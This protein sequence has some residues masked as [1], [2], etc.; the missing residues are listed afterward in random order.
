MRLTCDQNSRNQLNLPH[1]TKTK[2]DILKNG[3]QQCQSGR[4]S[5]DLWWEGFVKEVGFE[6]G[7]KEWR[8][9]GCWEWWIYGKS[10]TGMRRKIRVQDG[11]T[12]TRLSE[13]SREL[14][15][16]KR[17][18]TSTAI[19][20]Y[21]GNTKRFIRKGLHS[22]MTFSVTQGHWKW[23]DSI[24]HILLPIYLLFVVMELFSFT[25]SNVLS[26]LGY[27]VHPS[28]AGIVPKRLNIE[29]RNNATR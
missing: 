13:R 22:Q 8:S 9:C 21:T 24:R 12:S 7:G 29:S 6:L 25:V 2:P 20:S 19:R 15:P 11:E 27:S 17:W 3:E 23:R 10:W 28:Y 26:L 4:K 14:I 5:E 16:E 1:G 18:G